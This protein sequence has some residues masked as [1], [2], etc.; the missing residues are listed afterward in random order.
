MEFANEDIVKLIK[1]VDNTGSM[2][3]SCTAAK[4]S[5]EQIN[6]IHKLLFNK[7]FE[8]SVY[9]DYDSYTPNKE[10][11]GYSVLDNTASEEVKQ[12]WMTKFMK[13]NGGGGCPDYL[14]ENEIKFVQHYLS[15]TNVS[16][17]MNALL[18]ITIPNEIKKPKNK[19]TYKKICPS[20]DQSRC[21][22]L[23]PTDDEC[24]FC[25]WKKSDKDYIVEPENNNNINWAQC[26]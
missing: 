9:G 26:S 22:T 5:Y 18:E 20:C 3:Q 4:E 6:S 7:S 24:A 14:E 15:V 13:P 12:N 17:N 11:G 1:L 21:F 10:M 2:G 8:L 19:K 23:F 16:R 25:L